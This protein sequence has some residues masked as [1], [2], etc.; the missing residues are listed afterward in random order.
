[1]IMFNQCEA[2]GDAEGGL[3]WRENLEQDLR[4]DTMP[5]R[6]ENFCPIA[7]FAGFCKPKFFAGL[8]PKAFRKVVGEGTANRRHPGFDH[9]GFDEED[10]H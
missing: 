2:E 5:V 7:P 9:A 4:G 10:R 3:R 8:Y 1:M 6:A